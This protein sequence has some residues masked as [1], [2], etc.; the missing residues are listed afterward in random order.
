ME[1][2]LFEGGCGD[3][4]ARFNSAASEETLRA[5]VSGR[6]AGLVSSHPQLKLRVAGLEPCSFE[7]LPCWFRVIVRLEAAEASSHRGRFGACDL[8]SRRETET[9]GVIITCISTL[10]FIRTMFA[11]AVAQVFSI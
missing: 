5:M 4:I 11:S 3:A 7:V 6:Y 1:A 2:G 10:T 9:N 8:W